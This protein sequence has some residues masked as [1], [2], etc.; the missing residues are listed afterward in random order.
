MRAI[1][2]HEFGGP[3]VLQLERIDELE[4]ASDEVLIETRAIGVNPCD[5]LRRQGLW[6]DDLPLIPGSDVAGVVTVTGDRVQR[7]DVDDRVYGTIPHL[8][9]SGTRGDRQGVYAESVVAREDRLAVLP[10]GVSFEVGA[11]LGLVGITAWRALMHFGDL[12]PGQ[13]CLVHGGS[14]G[15]GH[16]A[17]QLASTL[18]ATVIATA[19]ADRRDIVR[20]LGADVVLDY[21]TP[22]LEAAIDDAAPDGVDVVL[23]H[24]LGEYMQLD[25]NVA[26]YGG[27]V[28]AIGGNYDSPTI[29]DLTEAIGKDLTIQPMDMFNEPDIAGV[30]ERLSHLLRKGRLT[31]EIADTY[32]LKEAAEAQRAVD[33]ESFTGKLVLR[34]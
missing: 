15:V 8:N 14:G 13:T 9:V 27:T 24:R 31:V 29:E 5:S 18:G 11:G 4:P 23:D 6:K 32:R 1:Q 17:V 12:E 16:V 26:N 19:S 2:Y 28:V 21:A 10:E 22:D 33:E 3:E 30:L 7:F 25:V 34:P 20:E